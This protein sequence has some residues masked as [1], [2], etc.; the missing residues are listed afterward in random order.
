MDFPCS[1]MELSISIFFPP[2]DALRR[3]VV[4]GLF[5]QLLFTVKADHFGGSHAVFEAETFG[6]DIRAA[7]IGDTLILIDIKRFGHDTLLPVELLL[8]VTVN[9]RT[10]FNWVNSNPRARF[11]RQKTDDR[12][13]R[14]KVEESLKEQ[15]IDLHPR[16]I[17]ADEKNLSF[18]SSVF[19]LLSSVFCLLTG[20]LFALLGMKKQIS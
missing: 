20:I 11:R 18:L 17:I 14:R 16:N 8:A 7:A 9:G 5:D 19:C 1:L 4:H 10:L 15:R 13:E 2:V 3:A 6:T 12:K